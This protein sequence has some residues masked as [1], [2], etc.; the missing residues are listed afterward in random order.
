MGTRQGGV[1]R[2]EKGKI[3]QVSEPTKEQRFGAHA[4]HPSASKAAVPAT[5][6]SKAIAT[7][8]KS[9]TGVKEVSNANPATN[10]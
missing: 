9:S 5:E 10:S 4:E 3:T 6:P 7:T 1:Y 8:V 2:R